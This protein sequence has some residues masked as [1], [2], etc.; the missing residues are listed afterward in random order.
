MAE[1][2][3]ARIKAEILTELRAILRAELKAELRIELREVL[4][5]ELR[6]ELGLTRPWLTLAKSFG[7]GALG[8]LIAI[9][10][11]LVSR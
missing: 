6:A 8:A 4:R 3:R 1:D 10:Q 2:E 7:A 11:R 5:A 9:V